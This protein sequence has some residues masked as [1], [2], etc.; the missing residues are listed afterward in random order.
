VGGGGG[1]WWVVGGGWWWVVVGVG[2]QVQEKGRDQNGGWSVV[3]ERKRG[4]RR[5]EQRMGVRCKV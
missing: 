5:K 1:W 2:V 3:D 4:K